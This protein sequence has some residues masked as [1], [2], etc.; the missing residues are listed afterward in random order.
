MIKIA[1]IGASYLQ[2]PLV[3]KAKSLGYETHCF[4]W[5]SD[6]SICKKTADFFYPISILEKER[7]EKEMKNQKHSF[8]LFH[9]YLSN[10]D[11]DLH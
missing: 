4:A 2:L 11:T 3:E 10:S 5:E 9:N 7:R 1:I 6:D 8:T